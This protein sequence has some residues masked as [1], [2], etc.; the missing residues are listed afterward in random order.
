MG[1]NIKINNKEII[2][3]VRTLKAVSGRSSGTFQHGFKDAGI[4]QQVGHED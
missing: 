2:A 1:G 4:E 3:W